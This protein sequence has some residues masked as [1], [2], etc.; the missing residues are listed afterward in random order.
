MA[1]LGTRWPLLEPARWLLLQ[2]LPAS[3]TR[4]ADWLCVSAVSNRA[5]CGELNY[6]GVDLRDR[7]YKSMPSQKCMPVHSHRPAAETSSWESAEWRRASRSS[8]A[9]RWKSSRGACVTW[10]GG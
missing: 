10:R 1:A 8:P 7:L 6:S 4:E 3:D 9:A 5:S 2:P